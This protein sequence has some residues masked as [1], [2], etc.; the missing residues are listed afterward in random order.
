MKFKYGNYVLPALAAGMLAFSIIQVVR[1][2]QKP[3]QPPPVEPARTPFG[4]TVAGAGVV[5]PRSEN[6]SVGTRC[7]AWC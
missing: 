3:P 6:I 2:Q 4:N 7:P 5:E 1:G